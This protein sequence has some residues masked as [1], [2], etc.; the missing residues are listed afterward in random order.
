[1]FGLGYQELLI[2]V[3]IAV[4]VYVGTWPF[5]RIARK[6]GFSAWWTATLFIPFLNIV[7]VWVF[8]YVSWP[9]GPQVR[10]V[11]AAGT[12]TCPECST[13]YD[14]ADYQPDSPI[15]CS[16]CKAPLPRGLSR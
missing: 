1:M 12:L 4:M 10:N 11:V 6:A 3:V 14:P 8:A 2:L 16:A 13:V 15:Y 9:K 5:R 7:M